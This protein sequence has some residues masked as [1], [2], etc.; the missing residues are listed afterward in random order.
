MIEVQLRE[1]AQ[2]YPLY[3]ST[4]RNALSTYA[5][6]FDLVVSVIETFQKC[7]QPNRPKVKFSKLCD[8]L[9]YNFGDA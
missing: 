8:V 6:G 9:N 3:C 1:R 5:F 4:P 7:P 2:N